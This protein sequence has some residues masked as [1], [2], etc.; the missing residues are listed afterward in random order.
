MI[1]SLH[2]GTSALASSVNKMPSP[3]KLFKSADSGDKGYLTQSDMA[4]AI[5]K[6]SPEGAKLS[7]EDADAMAKKAFDKLDTNNDGKVNQAEFEKGAD[8]SRPPNG[9][10]P[11]GAAA[12][13]RGAGGKAPASGGGAAGTAGSGSGSGSSQKVYEAADSN[14]DGKVSEQEQLA[15]DAK[16]P[17][18]DVAAT[19]Q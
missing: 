8:G 14:K 3:E 11:A 7:Q 2:G 16:H 6:V 19:S 9:P 12:D 1:S 18:A 5:V 10:P 13:A 15:Y 17:K 4:S